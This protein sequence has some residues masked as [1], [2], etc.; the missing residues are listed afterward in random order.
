MSSTI[1]AGLLAI[2]FARLGEFTKAEAA[3]ARARAL[4]KGGDPIGVLDVDIATSA[5]L[6]ERGDLAEGEALATSCAAL[7]EELGA[8]ACAVPANVISGAAHLARNDAAGA[9]PPLERGEELSHVSSMGS[10]QTLAEGMLGAVHARLGD[11]PAATI[12]WNLAL[13]RAISTEDRYGEA[14]TLW[15][16]AGA[17]EQATD[18]AAA[19][20]DIDRAVQLFEQMEARPSLARALRDQARVL[21]ALGRTADADSVDA[22]SKAIAA[23]LGLK[24]FA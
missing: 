22:R 15:Q 20:A 14:T 4:A 23:E 11:L 5:L 1:L 6:V 16:R 24:D 18:H 2:G 8:I 12:G 7:S 13:E 10:F 3:L 9:K 17:L 19:L 21:R